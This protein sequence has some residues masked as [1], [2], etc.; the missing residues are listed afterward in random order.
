MSAFIEL[1]LIGPIQSTTDDDQ[2]F[3]IQSVVLPRTCSYF[4]RI[5]QRWIECNSDT[6]KQLMID[7]GGLSREKDGD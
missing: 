3:P 1:L 2:T 4:D 7:S 5:L 6:V